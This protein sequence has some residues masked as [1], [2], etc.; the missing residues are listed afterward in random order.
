MNVDKVLKAIEKILE[1]KY[2]CKVKVSIVKEKQHE[3]IQTSN[4]YN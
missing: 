1:S 4:R 2:N 3:T